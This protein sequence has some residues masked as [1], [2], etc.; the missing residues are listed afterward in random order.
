MRELRG[1]HE[2]T[3]FVS[4]RVGVHATHFSPTLVLHSQLLTRVPFLT[5][6]LTFPAACR[7]CT[8]TPLA[9]P[10]RARRDKAGCRGPPRVPE[11]F[12]CRH[13]LQA[14]L[15]AGRS[16]RGSSR[17]PCLSHVRGERSIN[18]AFP[19]INSWT[20]LGVALDGRVRG[21]GVKSSSPSSRRAAMALTSSR[22]GG[23]RRPLPRD[24]V[25]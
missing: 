6:P 17:A 16:S 20:A 5:T 4:G 3:P 13:A 10:S 18:S 25:H 19:F 22:R 14:T 21:V 23:L 9:P 11:D 12:L 1:Q 8:L 7:G 24:D 2:V 15:L